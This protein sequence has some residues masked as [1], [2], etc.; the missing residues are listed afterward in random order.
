TKRL[1]TCAQGDTVRIAAV[2]GT[3]DGLLR[4]LDA[5][6][7]RIGSRLSVLRSHAFDGSMD[8]KPA[9]GAAFSLSKDV[10][11]LLHVEPA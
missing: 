10:C 5:K 1:S 3:A 4:L 2:S 6:G 11:H 7:L 8:L 9:S